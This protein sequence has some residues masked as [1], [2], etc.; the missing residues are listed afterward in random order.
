M[1]NSKP[2]ATIEATMAI[3]VTDDIF[4]FPAQKQEY[5][6]HIHLQDN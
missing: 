6:L 2:E 5:L 4:V 3:M 1:P